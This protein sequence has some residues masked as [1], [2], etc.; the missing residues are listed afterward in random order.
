MPSMSSKGAESRQTMSR[1]YKH[2]AITGWTTAKSEK[3]DKRIHNR[4]FRR[5]TCSKL[6]KETEDYLDPLPDEIT[7][8][9]NFAKDGKIR[10]SP[11]SPYYRK[12]LRK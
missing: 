11:D 5:R 1:S 4:R 8:I 2:N 7:N 10:Y 6:I 12:M 3:E 9:W